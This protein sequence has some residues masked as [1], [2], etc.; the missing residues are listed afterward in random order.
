MKKLLYSAALALLIL[1]SCTDMLMEDNKVKVSSDYVFNTP[2]GLSRASIA[3]YNLERTILQTSNAG[4]FAALMFDA[5]SDIMVCRTGG[6]VEF[7]RSNFEA[8]NELILA[9]WTNR[10]NIIGKANEIIAG[11]ERLGLE[12]PVVKQAWGEAKLFRARMYF[13]LYRRFD[14]LYLNLEP[15][16]VDN[17][18]R[19]F[20]PAPTEKVFET[21]NKDL[22]DAMGALDWQPAGNAAQ[23]Y[24][25]GRMTRTI[26]KHVK[27]Q[28]AM[29]QENWDEAIKQCE[30]IFQYSGY[31]MEESAIANFR[32]ENLNTKENLY[33]F[34]FSES[35][36][37]GGT[38]AGA[39]VITGHHMSIH[40][41]PRYDMAGLLFS[42]EYG[43]YG[44][45]RH[46]PN[47]H[48]F[49]LYDQAKDKRYNELF[50]HQYI[51]NNPSSPNYGKVATCE[52][53][54]FVERLHPMSMK[55][56]DQW[57]NADV[58][59]RQYSF[60]DIVIYRLAETYLIAAEAYM[61][62]YGGSH[63][64]AIEY[65]NKTWERAGND[66]ENGPI[67]LDMIIDED[68]RECCFEG[69]R[70]YLLKRVGQLK[71]RVRAHYGETSAE[72]PLM[73]GTFDHSRRNFE[74][75]H[76]CWPIPLSQ[77]DMMGRENFPQTEGWE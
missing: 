51:N 69:T 7:S 11:A 59:S 10:Y 61:R 41:T 52:P 66:H 28:V 34:Q 23:G 54:K 44:W 26:A 57:T 31:S 75:K 3:L 74:D 49:T 14:R 60:K 42:A 18:E 25:Y 63:A 12:D 70:W 37:G 68:A 64:K 33:V 22:D 15:T 39:G 20:T 43:G 29:W 77:V 1:P 40:T 17:L 45:G 55:Y 9:F 48:L 5:P 8:P 62:K 76:L 13:D 72:N 65:Y 46:Y 27:A 38:V 4:L 53:S 35:V 58:P 47:Y 32:G 73:S 24:E 16:T 19:V 56:F 21:I 36:A 71:E 2:D 67:T 50:R 6:G 30:D